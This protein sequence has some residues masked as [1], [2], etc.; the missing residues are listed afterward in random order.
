MAGKS[1]VRELVTVWGFDV[2]K[3]GLDNMQRGVDSMKSSL[4]TLGI[5]TAAAASTV[6]LLLNEAGKQEQT[7]VAFKTMLGSAEEAKEL[8]E[9]LYDFA[10]TT[11]FTIPGIEKNAK[12]LLGMGIESDQLIG[13]LRALGDV[14]AGLSVPM[15]RLALNFGQVK[16]QGKLTGRELRD[17]AIAGVPLL[18]VLAK[19]AGVTK[20]EIQDMVSAG[21]I[22]FK[23]VEDA[24]IAMTTEGGRFNNLMVAQSKTL[25]GLISNAQDFLIL[26]ARDLGNE[27]LP[28][29]KELVQEFLAWVEAN[30]ELIK[31]D[32]TTFLKSMVELLKDIL[33]LL[34]TFKQAASGLVTVFGGWN[35]ALSLVFKSFVAI[36]GLKML[37]ALGSM[38]IGVTQLAIAW[39]TMGMAALFA[40][41]KMAAIPIA[42]GAVIAAIGLIAEDVLAFTQGRDSVF[43][44]MLEGITTIFDQLSEK[45][46]AFN[47]FGKI[48]IAGLMTPIRTII[49]GFQNILEI[50]DVIRGKKGFFEAARNIGSNIANTFGVGTTDSLSSAIGLA[51]NANEAAQSVA[52]NNNPITGLGGAP[53]RDGGDGRGNKN[54]NV[55]SENTFNLNLTGMDPD[56][57]EEMV[58]QKLGDRFEGILR[59]TVRD[60]EDVVER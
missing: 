49:N 8:L 12:L 25:K 15:E 58:T 17:F 56:R 26:F 10:R 27:I 6:G 29:S 41:L 54:V 2:D 18:D 55:K 60:G 53:M 33:A 28:M 35:N 24:F 19:Q 38:A 22:G 52:R 9:D 11:P 59:E 21:D 31:S 16:A 47:T 13:T 37:A 5:V 20:S 46:Q 45:F 50:I 3:R 42:I 57:A 23:Q 36:M 34:G 48:I 43:G 40:Q 44:R 51:G 39:R 4:R 7:N 14:S 32:M 1:V 30:R